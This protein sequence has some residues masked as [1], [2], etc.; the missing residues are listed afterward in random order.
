MF[1]YRRRRPAGGL[2]VRV[3]SGLKGLGVARNSGRVGGTLEV[4][5]GLR[6]FPE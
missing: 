4:G 6:G 2:G 5:A 1:P 3:K